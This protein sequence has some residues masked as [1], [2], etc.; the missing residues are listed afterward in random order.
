MVLLMEKI[1][2]WWRCFG[3]FYFGS[4]LEGFIGEEGLGKMGEEVGYNSSEVIV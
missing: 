3:D 1:R 4:C 2:N